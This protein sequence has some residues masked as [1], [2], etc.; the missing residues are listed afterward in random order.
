MTKKGLAMLCKICPVC[1]IARLFPN[2][3]FA[4]KMAEAEKNCPACQA[5]RELYGWP[6][7]NAKR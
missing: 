3:G 5:Y 6:Q 1:N 2:S 4:K 7:A